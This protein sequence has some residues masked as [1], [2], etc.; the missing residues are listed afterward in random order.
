MNMF[1]YIMYDYGY[2]ILYLWLV[3]N[4]AVFLLKFFILDN[5]MILLTVFILFK[6]INYF[7]N[8]EK[9]KESVSFLLR[10]LP[11]NSKLLFR[12]IIRFKL[13][14]ENVERKNE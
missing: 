11:E 12:S 5:L 1:H 4:I 2:R 7:R 9:S 6:N 10:I 13:F 3:P 14:F 8:D